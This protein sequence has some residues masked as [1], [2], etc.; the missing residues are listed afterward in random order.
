MRPS[1]VVPF[2]LPPSA[3]GSPCPKNKIK[4][5]RELRVKSR[6]NQ[7]S[8]QKQ[9]RRKKRP[10]EACALFCAVNGMCAERV[11]VCCAKEAGKR[12]TSCRSAE[13]E[14]RLAK[15]GQCFPIM[16]FCLLL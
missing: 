1:K 12:E 11:A 5:A 9:K 14:C 3:P 16:V 6:Y 10:R 15:S 2:S 8:S 4:P 13:G 7:D